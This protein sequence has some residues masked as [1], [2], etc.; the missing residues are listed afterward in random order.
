MNRAHE[1]LELRSVEMAIG[2]KTAAKVDSERLHLRDRLSDVLRVQSAREIDW[3]LDG[4]ANF[5][6]HGPI[7]SAAGAAKLFGGKRW[8][9]GIEKKCVHV[10]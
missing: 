10:G 8:I 3:D 2:T 4:I 9:P 5:P 7:V 6:A 1:L